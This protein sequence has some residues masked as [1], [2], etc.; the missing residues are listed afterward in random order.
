MVDF[1]A[2]FAVIPDD[3]LRGA[4]T[5]AALVVAR[6]GLAVALAPCDGELDQ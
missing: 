1:V 2:L 3:A 4:V 6:R 5:T